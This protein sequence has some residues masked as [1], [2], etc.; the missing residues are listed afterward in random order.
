[1][2]L[3]DSAAVVALL[4]TGTGVGTVLFVWM[5][6]LTRAMIVVVVC[7]LSVALSVCLPS[8]FLMSLSMF[9]APSPCFFPCR[10]HRPAVVFLVVAGVLFPLWAP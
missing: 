6:V 4:L 8:R 10:C 7:W 5:L 1:M 9:A 3:L 2:L